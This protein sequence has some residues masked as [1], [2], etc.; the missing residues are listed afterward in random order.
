MRL[1]HRLQL[2][3]DFVPPCES[4]ADIG[5][6]HGYVPLELLKRGIVEKAYALDI[7]EGPLERA[8]LHRSEQ[9]L[10]DKMELRLSDGLEKLRP[11][12][13]ET[14]VI[15]GM[16][17]DLTVRILQRGKNVADSAKTLVLS[18]HSEWGEVRRYLEKNG[19]KI[20]REAMIKDG[21]KYYL[22]LR[23]V[24]GVEETGE[25]EQEFGKLLLGQKDPVLSEYLSMLLR[26]Y[27]NIEE[28]LAVQESPASLERQKEIKRI[29]KLIREAKKQCDRKDTGD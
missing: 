28:K 2:V 17:G 25:A 9:G 19:R 16:G 6:D 8:A 13:A 3:A 24:H 10:E 23:A 20:D 22:V 29:L 5:T 7:N 26:R 4:V 21:G 11:E 1:S 12:E 18:P 27:E 14:L 15:A